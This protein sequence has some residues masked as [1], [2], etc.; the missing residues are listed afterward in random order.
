MEGGRKKRSF[1]AEGQAAGG[2]AASARSCWRLGG[3]APAALAVTADLLELV[4]GS[5][6]CAVWGQRHEH[7]LQITQVTGLEMAREKREFQFVGFARGSAWPRSLVCPIW[8]FHEGG[9]C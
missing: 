3:R 2:A 5:G 8:L 9:L 6:D 1:R 4:L 7:P